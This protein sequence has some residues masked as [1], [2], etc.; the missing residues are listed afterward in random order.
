M[1][2]IIRLTESDLARIVKRVIEEDSLTFGDKVRNKLGKIVGIP[3]TTEDEE[4]LADDILS[5]VESG[6][7]EIL[8]DKFHGTSQGWYKIKVSLEDGNYGVKASRTS[9]PE[10]AIITDTLVKTPDGEKIY[11]PK[12]YTNKLIKTIKNDKGGKGF[13]YPKNR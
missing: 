8:D 6:D 11:L 13:E 9:T 4:R 7:Y 2:K 5:K 12:G 3:E 1:A 10:G